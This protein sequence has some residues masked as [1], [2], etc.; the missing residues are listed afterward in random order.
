MI[1]SR[2]LYIEAPDELVSTL[3]APDAVTRWVFPAGVADDLPDFFRRAGL[4]GG[5]IERLQLSGSSEGAEGELTLFP[6]VADL[7]AMTPEMRVAVY[8]RLAESG[9]NENHHDPLII[10]G[11]LD[12]WLRDVRLRPE[13][14]EKL[15]RMTYPRGAVRI[16]SDFPVLLSYA[17]SDTEVR[18]ILRLRTRFQTLIAELKLTPDTDFNAVYDYWSDHRRA[19]SI[20]PFLESLA[21]SPS[22]TSLDLIHLLPAFARRL[23]YTYPTADLAVKGSEFL[24][25][26]HYSSLNFFNNIPRAYYLNSQLAAANL[27]ESYAGVP[28]P[29]RFG[30]VL[31]FMNENDDALHSCVY[32]AD[33]IV[34]TKNGYHMLTPWILMRLPTLR[35]LYSHAPGFRIQGFRRKPSG[36]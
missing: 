23:L 27:A 19:R 6:T 7:E 26:C 9:G 13:L 24:P 2:D 3:K 33:D 11:D 14:K 32:V 29:F 28:E 21:E 8:A 12:A 17:E 22:A 35:D 36:T 34:F 25:D 4:P 20:R 15:R 16:F 5:M 30:D 10:P 18:R 31:V 1:E